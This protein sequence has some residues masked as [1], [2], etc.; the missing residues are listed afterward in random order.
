[1]PQSSD[2]NKKGDS[3]C[4]DLDPFPNSSTQTLVKHEA[5]REQSSFHNGVIEVMGSIVKPTISIECNHIVQNIG[6]Q[7]VNMDSQN[8]GTFGQVHERLANKSH[9]SFVRAPIINFSARSSCGI[10]HSQNTSTS[11]VN[12]LRETTSTSYR[13]KS[14]F[15]RTE[16]KSIPQLHTC[17]ACLKQ[18]F[19]R[20]AAEKHVLDVHLKVSTIALSPLEKLKSPPRSCSQNVNQINTLQNKAPEKNDTGPFKL[21]VARK[22]VKSYTERSETNNRVAKP[23]FLNPVNVTS[24]A[25]TP[26]TLRKEKD[27]GKSTEN[28]HKRK[29]QQEDGSKVIGKTFGLLN[30]NSISE[31]KTERCNRIK[32]IVRSPAEQ[33]CVITLDDDLPRASKKL[34]LQYESQ[35]EK[36]EQQECDSGVVLSSEVMEKMDQDGGKEKEDNLQVTE[37]DNVEDSRNQREET[38]IGRPGN[39]IPEQSEV[40]PLFETL[41]QVTVI[42]ETNSYSPEKFGCNLTTD[43]STEEDSQEE[44]NLSVLSTAEHRENE[45][46]ERKS[47]A[48]KFDLPQRKQILSENV[49]EAIENERKSDAVN[50]MEVPGN[51]NVDIK[52]VRSSETENIEDSTNVACETSLPAQEVSE[53]NTRKARHE[54]SSS[55]ENERNQIAPKSVNGLEKSSM[56]TSSSVT[57]DI[58]GT[59]LASNLQYLDHFQRLHF[60]KISRTM[61][62]RGQKPQYRKLVCNRC[63]K[64]FKKLSGLTSHMKTCS[65][66]EKGKAS[67]NAKSRGKVCT[68]NN[69]AARFALKLKYEL[70]RFKRHFPPRKFSGCAKFDPESVRSVVEMSRSVC[71]SCDLTF[72]N[73]SGLVEHVI[74]RNP[75]C[76]LTLS[77]VFKVDKFISVCRRKQG[78]VHSFTDNAPSIE[79]SG[80]PAIKLMKELEAT[81]KKLTILLLDGE[82]GFEEGFSQLVCLIRRNAS[83]LLENWDKFV[84][85][86]FADRVRFCY[87][88]S[89]IAIYSQPILMNFEAKTPNWITARSLAK[90]LIQI[91]NAVILKWDHLLNSQAKVKQ[92]GDAINAFFSNVVWEHSH[93]RKK[94]QNFEDFIC[95]DQMLANSTVDAF[96]EVDEELIGNCFE[97]FPS[98]GSRCEITI[99]TDEFSSEESVLTDTFLVENV[100]ER[101]LCSSSCSQS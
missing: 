51:K 7:Y 101:E 96:D 59:V 97:M 91:T 77:P 35:K 41:D 2:R 22:S 44:E 18:F 19:T 87:H 11:N 57:C 12:P 62:D 8:S 4:N 83:Y 80:K 3:S 70:V 28:E 60:D 23:K 89:S 16:P 30:M 56:D 29:N 85:Q 27:R 74:E 10:S 78:A 95:R 67:S 31:K 68:K 48:N 82:T 24:K 73:I 40:G 58:C 25:K 79:M 32:V 65:G 93:V 45:L 9:G 43:C 47:G 52:G 15:Q 69:E 66:V 54:R 14:P 86:K 17:N 6:V 38:D 90:F 36:V 5:A 88:L 84:N 72:S 37:P 21:N 100:I 98:S 26:S 13:S 20:E 71:S 53:E 50:E 1:M 49:E 42:S 63:N 34:K 76:T 33:S 94:I 61:P 55:A 64:K 92:P 99:P 81:S 39:G 46:F 75:G